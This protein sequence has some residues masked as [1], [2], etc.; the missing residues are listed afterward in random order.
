M[1]L[2]QS[3]QIATGEQALGRRIFIQLHA[4]GISLE[5]PAACCLA[6]AELPLP[7]LVFLG[8]YLSAVERI[9]LGFPG[10]DGGGELRRLLRAGRDGEPAD[11]ILL[12][13]PADVETARFLIDNGGSDAL[14]EE[15]AAL[16]R[17]RDMERLQA[18][19]G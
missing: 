16:V 6:S 5:R 3:L 13:A 14:S 19:V 12:F 2:A 1:S 7:G 15:E 8:G 17:R 9:H 11:C 18:M 10:L 4:G